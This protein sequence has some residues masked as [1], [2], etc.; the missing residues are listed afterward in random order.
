M[1]L[2]LKNLEQLIYRLITAA[3]GVAE[4]IAVERHLPAGGLANVIVGDDRLSA[5]QHLDIYADMYFY[6]LLEV[7]KED[8]PATAAVLDEANFH[9]VI[10]GYLLEYPPT[11]PSALWAG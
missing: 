2:Q 5:E 3:S 8:Y 6:R 1:S 10:T 11:E 9:N 4:G 7:L